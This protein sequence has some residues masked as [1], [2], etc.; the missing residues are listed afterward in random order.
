MAAQTGKTA[1]TAKKDTTTVSTSTVTSAPT[2]Q[3]V[4]QTTT[5]A[6]AAQKTA[7]AT[8]PTRPA[9][10]A[11]S[12]IRLNAGMVLIALETGNSSR[13]VKA[14]QYAL[15]DRGFDPGRR[16]GVFDQ[17]T[18]NSYA[19]YQ[20]SIGEPNDGEPTSASLDYLGFDLI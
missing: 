7:P 17:A 6:P 8:A 10:S 4:R 18:K 9:P 13:A 1:P 3:P 15:A 11:R 5:A 2:G 14:I 20:A 16:D 19:K 12:G